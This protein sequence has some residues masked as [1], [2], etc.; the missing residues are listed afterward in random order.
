MEEDKN[1]LLKIEI[2]ITE[3]G[4]GWN[5]KYKLPPVEDDAMVEFY[6]VFFDTLCSTIAKVPG[7]EKLAGMGA[8]IGESDEDKS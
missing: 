7:A 1:L 8:G 2:H 6:E 4:T 5:A 3:D